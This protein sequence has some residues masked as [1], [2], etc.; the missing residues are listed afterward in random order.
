MSFSGNITNNKFELSEF[1][2][3]SI[4][5]KNLIRKIQKPVQSPISQSTQS[6]K[7][8][9][10]VNG[11][12]ILNYKSNDVVYYGPL[13]KVSVTN[14]GSEYDIANPPIFSVSDQTGIGASAFCEVRGSISK[15][16]VVDGGF[17][18]VT[19]PTLKITGGNGKG[20]VATPNLVLKDHSVEFD[21]IETAGLVNL[22]NNLS[23]I[24]I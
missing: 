24:H 7:T 13:D 6:G 18:Y 10:L 15:I 17:D 14:S 11:V 3:K 23:L 8:G 16:E 4:R 1:N 2:N 21:S 5:S 19:I 20:C 12:E 9:I 22:T